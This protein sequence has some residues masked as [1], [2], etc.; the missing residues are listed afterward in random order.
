[1]NTLEFMFPDVGEGLAQGE[2]V[3]WH[4]APGDRVKMDTTLVEVETDK[5]IVEIPSPANGTLLSQGAGQ[6]E[7][8]LV[9]AVLATLDIDEGQVIARTLDEGHDK[10]A[11]PEATKASAEPG[12]PPKQGRAL[13][14]PAI[15]KAAR[16]LGLDLKSIHGTGD[17]G[18]ITRADLKTASAQSSK[19]QIQGS[20][21]T[22]TGT[23]PV[24]LRRVAM[25]QGADRVEPLQGLRRR[26]AETMERAWRE[27]PHIFHTEEIDA[28]QLVAAR[29]SLNDEFGENVANLSYM[30]FFVKACVL[31]LKAHPSFNASV[32]TQRWEVV[33]RHRYNIGIATATSEG[34]IVPV[35]HDANQGSLVE[36]G[37]EIAA[38]AA[39]ARIRKASV[40]QLSGGTFTIS[41]F[42][43]Y[44][45][46][47][48][49]PIIRPPEVAIAGFGR[50]RDAVIA[51]DGQPVVRPILPV[52][53]STDHRLNDGDNLGAFAAT[54]ISYLREPVR[55]L[56]HL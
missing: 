27:V 39:A 10:V 29:Q 7:T 22:T 25:P 34:L 18:Q 47:L 6:G 45:N 3:R 28:S 17:R 26:I 23:A 33:Y 8:L 31:A 30:P 12:A 43:S 37:A 11:L 54:L 51:L 38:L 49:M 24:T 16:E 44:G 52:I 46:G 19:P 50:I 40:T 15:R 21:A 2:I 48:G 5:A 4:A 42:G 35:L 41:N 14:S 36:L 13:A 55:L 56:G 53:V 9:G 20:A 1:M 32:D